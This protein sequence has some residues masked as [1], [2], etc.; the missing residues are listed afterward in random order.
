MKYYIIAGEASGD[1]HA[2][3]LMKELRLADSAFSCRAWG[4]DLMQEQGAELVKHY[5]DL[6]FMGFVE[7]IANLKTI[8]ANV[9]FCKE[10]ILKYNPDA[11][12]LVDYPGFNL[13]I[14]EFAKQK[15]IKVFYYI[16]PQ[17]WAW[18]ASRVK[19]IKRNVDRMLTILPFESDFY[20][21][22]N[23]PVTFVG[24]PLLD[25]IENRTDSNNIL[26]S[27]DPR[28]IIAL[29]PG[30]R[31]QEITTVLPLML[32]VTAKF[33]DYRFI[34]AAAPSVDKEF[35]AAVTRNAPVEII[36]GKTYDL[37]AAAHAALVTSGTATLEAA[38]FGVPE[39]VC[40]KG[41]VV[42]YHIA[43]RLIKV[44]YISLVNL[45]MDREI[46]KELIQDDLISGSISAELEK[47]CSEGPERQKMIDDYKALKKV[48]GGKGASARAAH[49]I[50]AD[51]KL[52]N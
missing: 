36:Y 12:I 10:D 50:V 28:K 43:R 46:V 16:S 35:Y 44:K 49:T 25:A 26:L 40:Y 18:K 22:Y 19:Q 51:L 6:A 32:S 17:V 31:K 39:V 2:A 42:S 47:I 41:N 45:I 20:K 3:N 37:L 1:L 38:L 4:G 11:L 9:A 30:S 13:R 23:Y 21:Q 52:K 33:P 8:L 15:G 14:A 27:S 48:L 7:V 5:R 24:H 29:L 34:V